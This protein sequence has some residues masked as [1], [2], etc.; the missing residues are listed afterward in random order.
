MRGGTWQQIHT[1]D[2]FSHKN[3]KF[4]SVSLW[5]GKISAVQNPLFFISL[6]L[7][8]FYYRFST[9]T[10]KTKIKRVYKFQVF[11]VLVPIV[12]GNLKL[13]RTILCIGT[14]NK[15]TPGG[16]WADPNRLFLC[17]EHAR[18]NR[19]KRVD[20]WFLPVFSS[21]RASPALWYNLKIFP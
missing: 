21:A 16:W 4:P 15:V 6:K 9:N 19:E 20:R 18:T 10:E 14:T 2:L 13:P 8:N 7:V 12:I 3:C 11:Q 1:I 17:T 5:K